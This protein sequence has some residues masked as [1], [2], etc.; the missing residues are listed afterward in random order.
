MSSEVVTAKHDETKSQVQTKVN[1]YGS[2]D[3]TQF[4]GQS[5]MYTSA[6]SIHNE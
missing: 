5:K 3:Y 1:L 4:H 6:L 2:S